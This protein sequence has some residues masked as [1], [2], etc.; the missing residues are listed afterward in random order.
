MRAGRALAVRGTQTVRAGVTATD[1]DDPLAARGDGR[2]TIGVE[3][4][5]PVGGLIGPRQ[6]LHGLMDAGEFPARDGQVA[7]IGGATG[8][9]HRVEALAELR[10]GDVDADVHSGHERGALGRHLFQAA[11]DMALLHL[12]LGDAVAQQAT[13]PIGAFEHGDVMAGPGQLLSRGQSGRA[14]ADDGDTF[15][16][17]KMRPLRYHPT[18]IEGVVDDLDLNLF[19]GHRVG[20]DS[21]HT[22]GLA[23]SRAQPSGELREVIGG[24]QALDR[25]LPAILAD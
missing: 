11:I 9:H 20:V 13:D 14:G 2:L 1:D 24:V 4:R 10:R 7:R 16:G 3:N 8:Q 23:G 21:Q 19:D 5:I 17:Q 6:I 18:F 15:P 22:G 25:V 12:E